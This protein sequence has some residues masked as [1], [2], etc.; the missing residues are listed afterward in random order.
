MTSKNDVTGDEL[1]SKAVTDAYREG[2]DRIFG[3]KKTVA[4]TP[5]IECPHCKASDGVIAGT[6]MYCG[7]NS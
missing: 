4:E 6:C 7:E 3:S 2:Y 1:V 5:V